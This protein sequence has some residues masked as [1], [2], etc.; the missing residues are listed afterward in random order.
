MARVVAVTDAVKSL[1]EV[2]TRFGLHR[3]EDEQFFSKWQQ[4]LPKLNDAKRG[5]LQIMRQRL[6]YHRAE[7]DLLE[8]LVMLLVAS[9]FRKTVQSIAGV[10]ALHAVP[11]MAGGIAGVEETSVANGA[12]KR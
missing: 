10:S 9:P 6:L 4:D 1:S 11:E 3:V 8:G 7:D 12:V 2:E 5:K